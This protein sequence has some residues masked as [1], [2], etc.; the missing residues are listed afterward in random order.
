[1]KHTR[2]LAML[3]ALMLLAIQG[4]ACAEILK[5]PMD[6]TGGTKPQ[7]TYEIGLMEY[8]D[9][10]IHVTRQSERPI[11]PDGKETRLYVLRVKIADPS[12]LRTTSM[13][14]FDKIGRVG[15][16]EVMSNRVNA[17]VA[18]GGDYYCGDAKRF[19]LRQGIVYKE[20][21]APNQD[22]LLIDEDGDFHIILAAEHPEDMD[23]TQI[24]GKK[25]VNAL[26]FGPAM[27]KDGVKNTDYSS[28]PTH[29]DPEKQHERMVLCQIGPLEYMVVACAHRGLGLS[30]MT[31]LIFSLEENV[32]QAYNLDGGISTQLLFLGRRINN[33]SR[34]PEDNRK[35]VDIVYFASAYQPD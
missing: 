20:T 19:V 28:A 21:M 7:R 15:D 34:A 1:M 30:E 12:Q 4:M 14:G 25:V 22:L 23:K 17:V 24:N 6:F 2:I 26:C 5:L 11:L 3:T 18:F 9:P 10:S 33:T 27:I 13:K 16:I 29:C 35:L 8:E 32:Q 31:D